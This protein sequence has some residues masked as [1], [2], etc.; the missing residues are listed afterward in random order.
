MAGLFFVTNAACDE[1]SIWY[2]SGQL[3]PT[4]YRHFRPS[5]EPQELTMCIVADI[6]TNVHTMIDLPVARKGQTP[7]RKVV[8]TNVKLAVK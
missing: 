2:S 5:F 3:K 8:F 1:R 4:S 6:V 7:L